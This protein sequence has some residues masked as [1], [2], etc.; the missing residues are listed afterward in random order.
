MRL[1]DEQQQAEGA[2]PNEQP[3]P[4]DLI[5]DQQSEQTEVSVEPITPVAA[6][7]PIEEPI[8]PPAVPGASDLTM[9]D[10]MRQ[11][12]DSDV[13]GRSLKRG[14]MVEGKVVQADREGVLVDVGLKH[15]IRIPLNELADGN[16]TTAEGVFSPDDKINAIVTGTAREKEGLQLSHRQAQFEDKWEE[17]EEAMRDKKTLQAMVIE[18]VKGGLVVDLGVRGFI[19]GSHVGA[20]G[21]LK[22]LDRFVGQSL[23]VKVL[24]IDRERRKVVVSNRLAEEQMFDQ[25]RKDRQE[26]QSAIFAKLQEGDIL[27]GT[28]RRFAA[29]GAFVDIGGYEG[30][31]HI[32]EMSW[33]RVEEPKDVLSEGQQIQV[34]VVKLERERGKVSLSLR[35]ATPDPWSE[36][37]DHYQVGATVTAPISRVVK[38]GA[39][40]RLPE[41]VE[42]FIPLSEMAARR[43]KNAEDVVR[44]GQII[45]GT[46]IELNPNGRRMVVSLKNQQEEADRREAERFQ[47]KN[48][49]TP[50]AGFTIGD[51]LQ[52]KLQG[53]IAKELGEETP[54]EPSAPVSDAP[55]PEPAADA[56]EEVAVSDAAAEP[57]VA[58][59]A[60]EP[61]GEVEAEPNAE[62]K[63]S[64]D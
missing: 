8:A 51:R 23:P 37:P 3:E 21:G 17:I 57:A 2:Q 41:Q 38:S 56:A 19:P 25:K 62:E 11:V 20:H 49:A 16:L 43:P 61:Q 29:Y 33:S 40:V 28:V 4:I 9:E 1:D 10:V 64:D 24:E 34:K 50:S 26:R 58:E 13:G 52:E 53:L 46:I 63:P 60:E 59:A 18:R 6:Q 48:R 47:Q 31:L 55:M 14:E 5:S 27:D 36:I 45:E 22:N 39:F 42:A 54:A 44:L 35:Q 15:E 32:S 30:L 12:E 7:Q